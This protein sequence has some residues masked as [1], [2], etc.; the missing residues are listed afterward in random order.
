MTP[1]DAVK[2]LFAAE[3]FKLKELRDSAIDQLVT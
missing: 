1:E 2:T 3:K